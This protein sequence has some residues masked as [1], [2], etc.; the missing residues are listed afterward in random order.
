MKETDF[1]EWQG[2]TAVWR[3][4]FVDGTYVAETGIPVLVIRVKRDDAVFRSPDPSTVG[5]PS[6]YGLD[7]DDALRDIRIVVFSTRCTHLCCFAGWHVVS[8]PPPSRDYATFTSTPPPTY[9]VYGLDPI[10]CVC[11][12]AQWDPMT[13]RRACI[14]A[15]RATLARCLST[16]PR[17]DRCRSSWSALAPTSLREG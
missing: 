12:G 6:G 5:L 1:A 3:G 10:Y 2:A 14:R 9:T 16:A 4:L 15:A 11:R 13:S 8:E 17:G 7:Y